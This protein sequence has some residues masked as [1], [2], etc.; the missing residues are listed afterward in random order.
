M[1]DISKLVDAEELLNVVWTDKSRPSLRWLRGQVGERKIP[2]T[3]IGRLIFFDPELVRQHLA[4]TLGHEPEY[5]ERFYEAAE[6]ILKRK[7]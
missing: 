2:F 3:R 1:N 6:R 4:V 7:A 5:R